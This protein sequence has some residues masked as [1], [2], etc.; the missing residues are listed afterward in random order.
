MGPQAEL[1]ASQLGSAGQVL[2]AR[3]ADNLDQTGII[4]ADAETQAREIAEAADAEGTATAQEE[5]DDE[6][7]RRRTREARN[8]DELR[9]LP[10]KSRRRVGVDT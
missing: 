6:T 1:I 7:E 5:L 8:I 3:I 2:A 4:N 10:E 9:R